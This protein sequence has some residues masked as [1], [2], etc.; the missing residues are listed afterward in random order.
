M[1][2]APRPATIDAG[3]NDRLESLV[4][5]LLLLLLLLRGSNGRSFKRSPLCALFPG[6]FII[7]FCSLKAVELPA[8]LKSTNRSSRSVN[9]FFSCG[10]RTADALRWA[11]RR[12]VFFY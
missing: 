12:I 9:L 2:T 11:S 3:H 7:F 10:I 8:V 5:L 1:K 4:P 6:E